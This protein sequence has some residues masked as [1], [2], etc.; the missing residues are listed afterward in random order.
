MRM[1][2]NKLP[3]K[4]YNKNTNLVTEP[5]EDEENVCKHQTC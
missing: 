4:A 5:E 2:H 1:E 3:T